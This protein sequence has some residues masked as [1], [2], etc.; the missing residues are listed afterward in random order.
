MLARRG[1]AITRGTGVGALSAV[2]ILLIA[3]CGSSELSDKQLRAQA[4][5]VC[6]TATTRT[7]RIQ[8]P[9][10]P[11]RG[12]A[13]LTSGIAAL[14]PEF[15]QLKAIR[16]PSDLAQVYAISVAAFSRKLA[17][18]K[19]AAHHLDRGADPVITIKRLQHRLAPLE[20]SE[21]GAWQALQIPAC[22]NR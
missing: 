1:A 10:S 4:A 11:A 12:A 19:T 17:A 15:D 22:L 2:A 3:G 18:L 7:D 5:H 14:Q 9:S 20:S 21:D 8:T 6:A 16:P 13:F